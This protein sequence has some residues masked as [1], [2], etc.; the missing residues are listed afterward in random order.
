MTDQSH[1]IFFK[2]KKNDDIQVVYSVF[3]KNAYYSM[4]CY[5]E[6]IDDNKNYCYIENLTDDE[7][8]AETFLQLMTNGKVYPVH[9]KEIAEDY[10]EK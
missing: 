4:E 7:G 1:K 3:F 5:R 9:I 2:T 6:G 8:E 10:F